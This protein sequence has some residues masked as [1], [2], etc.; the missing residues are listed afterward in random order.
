VSNPADFMVSSLTNLDI[1]SF[2]QDKPKELRQLFHEIG[3]KMMKSRENKNGKWIKD[4]IKNYV[5]LLLQ[6][7][8]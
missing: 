6:T 7:T 5:N 8:S 3:S 4:I 2:Y 1:L